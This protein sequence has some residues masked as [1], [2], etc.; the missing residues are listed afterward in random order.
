MVEGF[1][2]SLFE[3]PY[4]LLITDLLQYFSLLT[5]VSAKNLVGVYHD[6]KKMMKEDRNV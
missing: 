4:Q 3:F 6:F 5:G 1:K 2:I